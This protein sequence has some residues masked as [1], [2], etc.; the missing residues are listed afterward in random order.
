[1]FGAMGRCDGP[2]LGEDLLGAAIV[3][4]YEGA[5]WFGGWVDGWMDAWWWCRGG[6]KEGGGESVGDGRG[7]GGSF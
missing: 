4:E 1:M 3:Y 5:E 2:A 6:W 7:S